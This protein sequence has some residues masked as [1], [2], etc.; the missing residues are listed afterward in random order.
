VDGNTPR[1]QRRDLI[2]ALGDGAIDIL[3]NCGL[4]SE[5]LD[6]PGVVAAVL[7]R[8][9]KSLALYLQM[10]GR[11]LRPAPG[12]D[13]AYIL[14]HAGNVYRHGFPAAQRRWNLHGR[15]QPNAPNLRRCPECGAVNDADAEY[16][17]ACGAALH[18]GERERRPRVEVAGSRLAEAIEAPID[19]VALANMSYHAMLLWAAGSDGRLRR[20]R[21]ERVAQAKSYSDGWI[22]HTAGKPWDEVWRNVQRWREQQ[23]A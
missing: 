19:D 20:D 21:L 7:L 12:K 1:D 22:Y 3:C 10:V 16:C 5:G 11:A 8:P 13:C 4:I 9:T 23:D 2:A 18:S 6:V 17:E 15:E 14:D